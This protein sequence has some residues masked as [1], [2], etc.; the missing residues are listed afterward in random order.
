MKKDTTLQDV[1]ARHNCTLL[2]ACSEILAAAGEEKRHLPSVIR[3]Q[4]VPASLVQKAKAYR[5]RKT[6][7]IAAG[8]GGKREGAGR[9]VR[10]IPRVAVTVRLEP[11]EVER[12]KR[13]AEAK[14]R[15]VAGQIA[16]WIRRARI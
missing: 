5:A 13:I 6:G 9:P 7:Q 16:E 1:A 4:E 8:H 15:S 14:G 11:E 10:E 12:L 3:R 2:R